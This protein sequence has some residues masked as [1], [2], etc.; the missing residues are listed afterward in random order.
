MTHSTAAVAVCGL[1]RYISVICLLPLS[2]VTLLQVQLSKV[3]R[4]IVADLR[5]NCMED[6]FAEV[7]ARPT[8]EK[9]ISVRL[10]QSVGGEAVVV[11]QVDGSMPVMHQPGDCTPN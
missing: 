5:S 10:A 2:N 6:S 9:H 4:E 8:N 7:G 1:W 11:S 3:C